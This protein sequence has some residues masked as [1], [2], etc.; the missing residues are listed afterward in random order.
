MKTGTKCVNLILVHGRLGTTLFMTN[1][2]LSYLF[3]MFVSNYWYLTEYSKKWF[4]HR[5]FSKCGSVGYEDEMGSCYII[6]CSSV[7]STEI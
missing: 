4:V 1:V 6:K 5:V 7:Y 3:K 2:Q